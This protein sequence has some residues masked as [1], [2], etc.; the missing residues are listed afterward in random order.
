MICPHCGANMI[1][2]DR[3]LVCDFCGYEEK[4]PTEFKDYN[5][6]ITCPPGPDDPIRIEIQDSMVAFDAHPGESRSLKLDPGPHK[7]MF[8]AGK[9]RNRRMIYV[10]DNFDIVKISVSYDAIS[11][12]SIYLQIEQPDT[13]G[14]YPRLTDGKLPPSDNKMSLVALWLSISIIGSI[15][16]IVISMIDII[17]SRRE[18]RWTDPGSVAAMIIGIIALLTFTIIVLFG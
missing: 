9:K 1:Y 12:G 7:I 4:D 3:L 5:V 18:G 13:K 17:R 11:E 16:A 14:K 10:I 15:P 6:L 8:I 2:K